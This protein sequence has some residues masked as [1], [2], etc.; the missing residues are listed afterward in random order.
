MKRGKKFLS[1]I[2]IYPKKGIL[3]TGFV[4]YVVGG[5]QIYDHR[6]AVI[7]EWKS[8]SYDRFSVINKAAIVQLVCK[9]EYYI[10]NLFDFDKEA[11]ESPTHM[12][13]THTFRR[14]SKVEWIF[15]SELNDFHLGGENS[16]FLL[17]LNLED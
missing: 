14:V 10:V 12:L 2:E 17:N 8:N 4:K 1:L 11:H 13:E 7:E 15:K 5:L 6:K 9:K 16:I 3:K